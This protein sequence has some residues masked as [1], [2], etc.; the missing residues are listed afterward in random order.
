MKS[1]FMND[2][3]CQFAFRPASINFHFKVQ[4]VILILTCMKLSYSFD[5]I[6]QHYIG[7]HLPIIQI[8]FLNI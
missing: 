1:K 4:I 7:L 5:A 8:I 2:S 6:I 3:F